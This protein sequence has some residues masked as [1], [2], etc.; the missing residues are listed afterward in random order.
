M[1]LIAY[2]TALTLF[3]EIVLPVVAFFSG[4]RPGRRRPA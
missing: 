3:L 1:K 2:K 4:Y